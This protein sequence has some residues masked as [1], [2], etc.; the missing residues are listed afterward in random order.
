MKAVFLIKLFIAL[1]L[2]IGCWGCTTNYSVSSPDHAGL[3][4]NYFAEDR[5]WYLENIPFFECSDSVLQHVYYYR[6]KLYKAHIRHT[7]PD[8]YIITEFINHVAWDRDPY[9]TINAA[10]MHH[11]YEGRWLRNQKFMDGYIDYLYQQGGNNRRY[12]ES[13]G[14]AT[15]ARYLVNGDTSFLYRQLDSMIAIYEA[16]EDHFDSTKQLYYIPAMPDATEYTIAS[17]DASG[18]QAGFDGGVAFRPTINSY[19]S[20]N[21]SAIARIAA[22][23]GADELNRKYTL[24]A[25][26]L[27]S[28]IIRYLWHDTFVHFLD[29]YKEDNKYVHYWD[30]IRGREL[31]GFIPWYF[32]L[33]PDD[34]KYHLAW[35]NI[36]DTNRLLG[37]TVIVRMNLPMN[38]I[39]GNMLFTRVSEA[40]SGMARVG[41]TR[42]ARCSPVW[43]IFC[44]IT[45]SISSLQRIIYT[46]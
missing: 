41:L 29:R 18:G 34:P 15:L 5:A 6:W 25:N 36:L 43:L 7:G 28:N 33:P 45:D 40:A 10:S 44:T 21:A 9:C 37:P 3:A 13:I 16:W 20:A 32:N 30:Y 11:I 2:L 14:D 26:E 24:K 12:S 27:K 31:A 39:S 1:N 22:L 8:D 4:Y 17:I 42:P 46:P 19:M 23:Q 35:K 38:I